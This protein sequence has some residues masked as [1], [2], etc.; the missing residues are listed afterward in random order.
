M[1]DPSYHT[2]KQPFSVVS[3]T[4]SSLWD[5]SNMATLDLIGV[6]IQFKDWE[7]PWT[8]YSVVLDHISHDSDD[9][10]IFERIWAEACRPEHWQYVDISKCSDSC[11]HGR[12]IGFSWLPEE[13]RVQ[14]VRAASFQWK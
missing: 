10:A 3:L 9:R 13:A 4:A 2:R 12:E 8:F 6:A 5:Q 7:K 11:D 14:F 1:T